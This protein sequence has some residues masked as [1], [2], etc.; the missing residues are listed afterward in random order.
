MIVLVIF[1]GIAL[2]LFNGGEAGTTGPGHSAKVSG[3]AE[4]ESVAEN[5]VAVEIPTVSTETIDTKET[6]P[7]TQ[8]QFADNETEQSNQETSSPNV[9]TD[10]VDADYDTADGDDYVVEL[11][12]DEVIDFN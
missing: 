7:E 2:C 9:D 10:N 5:S 12:Q 8:I 3:T 6:I 11:E 4:T 1:G